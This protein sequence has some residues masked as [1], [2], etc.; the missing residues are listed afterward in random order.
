MASAYY[1]QFL[2][3]E[4]ATLLWCLE[5]TSKDIENYTDWQDIINA[6]SGQIYQ[7]ITEPSSNL[8]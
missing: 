1:L 3:Y 4:R 6:V 5:N 8:P 2:F 7:P